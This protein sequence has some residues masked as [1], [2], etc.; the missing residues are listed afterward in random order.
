[1]RINKLGDYGLFPYIEIAQ[2]AWTYFFDNPNEV[3]P[4]NV[5]E[6]EEK[7]IKWLNDNKLE[8][9]KKMI[10]DIRLIITPDC[11]RKRKTISEKKRQIC[12]S[13]H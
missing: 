3:P 8:L 6:L 11:M 5:K 9:T 1:M 2:S 10:R 4:K 12:Q 7:F 13:V